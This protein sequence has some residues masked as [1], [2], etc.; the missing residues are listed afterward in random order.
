MLQETRVRT[1][2]ITRPAEPPPAPTPEVIQAVVPPMPQA[3][4]P[5][6]RELRKPKMRRHA[7]RLR[8]GGDVCARVGW[9]KEI[10]RGGKSWRCRK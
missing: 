2:P 1:I 9:H 8:R 10:T 5:P 3:S 6:E 4:A 7:V